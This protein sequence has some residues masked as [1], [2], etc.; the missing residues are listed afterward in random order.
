MPELTP[1]LG[2]KKPLG[3]ETVSRAAFNENYDIIDAQAQKNIAQRAT[4]PAHPVEGD[5]WI[6]TSVTPNALKKYNGSTWEKVG[7]VSPGD[8]GAVANAGS[9]PSIQAGTDNGKPAS[10]IVGRI[11]IAT[12]TQII[13]R[14][15][16]TVWAKVGAVRWSDI[17]SKP[18]SYTPSAHK[19]THALGGNDALTPTDIGAETP[20]GA[21]A[22]VDTHA[23][24]TTAHSAT[25]AAVANKIILRD[26][27]G[28]A[29]VAAPNAADDIARKDTVDAHATRTDNPHVV[30][31]AQIG[32]ANILT[33]VKTVDGAESGLDAD[34]LDG[35]N[36]GNAAG[37]IPI[38]NGTVNANLNAD[39]VDGE[40]ANT[41]KANARTY[42]SKIV[43]E[44][45]SSA[46]SSPTNGQ[47]WYDSVN[48]K[49]KGYA[50]GAWV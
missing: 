8:I 32:A 46:P 2:I 38:S 1:K 33:Q 7:A 36:S 40:D 25:S 49:F 28:R 48:H 37:N 39:K 50:N 44:V 22:K 27:S 17:D 43:M 16:G 4:A 31:A 13:Y 35:L 15:T 26:A 30:T 5:L 42:N 45:N 12:D 24:L 20:A 47:I 19:A 3:N 10:G 11:Y 29:K 6:D 34:L 23:G 41:I 9:A 21:Q 14:D 18:V